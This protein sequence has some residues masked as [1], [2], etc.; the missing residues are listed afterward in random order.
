MDPADKIRKAENLAQD[1]SG[2]GAAGLESAFAV[3]EEDPPY[4]RVKMRDGL[5]FVLP[6]DFNIEHFD[7]LMAIIAISKIKGREEALLDLVPSDTTTH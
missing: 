6:Y 3:A 4:I 1:L 5:S 7:T 2:Y